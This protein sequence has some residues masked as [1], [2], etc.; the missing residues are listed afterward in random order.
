MSFSNS[1]ALAAALFTAALSNAAAA[2]SSCFSQTIV[3]PD[4][5]NDRFGFSL[6]LNGD[7][8]I[9]GCPRDDTDG[10][11]AGGVYRYRIGDTGAVF[12]ERWP[13]GFQAGTAVAIDGDFAAYDLDFGEVEVYQRTNSDWNPIPFA[14]SGN[15]GFGDALDIDSGPD[16]RIAISDVFASPGLIRVY[17]RPGSFWQLEDDL[18]PSGPAGGFDSVAMLNG[19]TIFAG[20]P[21]E[22]NR[23]AVYI[24][25]RTGSTWTEIQKIAPAAA[26][27]G[28]RYGDSISA[29]GNTVVIGAPGWGNG[30]A[31]V[32]VRPGGMTYNFEANLIAPTTND[33]GDAVAFA[34]QRAVIASELTD[35]ILIYVRS[36]T[37]WSLEERVP[38]GT[39]ANSVAFGGDDW[40][41][42]DF[43]TP[44]SPGQVTGGLRLGDDC[45]NNGVLDLCEITAGDA[46]D[47]D[48][49]GIPDECE[50]G[51]VTAYCTGGIHSGGQ[52]AEIDTVG[53]T[54]ISDNLFGVTVEGAPANRPGIFFY[55]GGQIDLPF[56][57][58]TRCVA[59]GGLGVHRVNPV[60]FTDGS[61]E[62][63][64]PMD[65]TATQFS[66]GPG[67][68]TGLSTWNFQY[69]FRDPS[70]PGGS[71]F[72]LTNAIE[73]T[74]CP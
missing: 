17:T 57:D 62:V 59:S 35:E 74:F 23:G 54:S 25:Q 58:G 14:P 4:V 56:G 36:G 16:P 55:G 39:R 64:L 13:G 34:G 71:G 15:A 22:G 5:A 43:G 9:V 47:K 73:V 6:A 32:Y 37:S 53:S 52:A 60:A 70:G 10:P 11:D 45:N 30:R 29:D 46:E 40:Y 65:F 50:C 28:A 24:F 63:L 2:Q 67:A 7:D 44:S 66:T 72:N 12:Q 3:G 69:W 31:Q 26:P 20:A 8:L 33:L 38:I 27:I 51:T 42:G 21:T 61:G 48:G 68:I 41:V 49:N 1:Q 19:A 18:I